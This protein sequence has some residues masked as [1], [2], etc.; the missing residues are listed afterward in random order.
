MGQALAL[1]VSSFTELTFPSLNRSRQHELARQVSHIDRGVLAKRLSTGGHSRGEFQAIAEQALTL[2]VSSHAVLAASGPPRDRKDAQRVLSLL[3]HGR[4]FVLVCL[5][6]SN[7]IVNETL[8]KSRWRS[9]AYDDDR[10]ISHPAVFLDSLTGGGGLIAVLISSA[11]IVIFGEILP[12]AL[13]SQHGL[14]IGARCTG[15]VKA[16]VRHRLDSFRWR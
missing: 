6:L 1:A 14:R 16:L 11:S 15:F 12:Q 10:P 2:P 3:S 9:L 7:V 4:H 8:R 5:L 13:C